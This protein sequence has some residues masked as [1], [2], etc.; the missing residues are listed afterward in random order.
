MTIKEL[1]DK[2]AE[3]R[4]EMQ[5]LLKVSEAEKRQLTDAENVLFN[6][7]M[8]EINKVDAEIAIKETELQKVELNK[9]AQPK[10]FSLLKAIQNVVNNRSF[11]DEEQSVIEQGI[12]EMRKSGQ[13]YAGQI[14]LPVEQR[15]I[16]A[17]VAGQGLENVAT[18]KLGILEPLRNELVFVK[19]GATFLTGL[20]GDVSIPV[21]A[22]SNVTWKGETAAADDASS[23]WTEVLLQPKRLTAY[24]DISKQFLIQDSNNAEALL[25]SDIIRA[26]SEKLESTLLGIAAGTATSPSGLGSLLSP[27]TSISTFSDIVAIEGALESANT[28]GDYTYILAPDVKAAMRTMSKDAGSGRFVYD[29]KGE[30]N[31]YKSYSTNSVEVGYGYVGNW[32]DYVL[33]QWG[34]VDIV[35]DPYSQA[36]NGAVRL[37]VNAYFDG[38]PRR[39]TSFVGFSI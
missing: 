18:D 30:I 20:V 21:Y 38:K 27:I 22:G 2:K 28:K 39:A 36:V 15:D 37:V 3:I 33:A 24:L 35:V 23:T 7:K 6:N 4:A 9:R 19:A 26:I 29:D 10:Q 32:N 8:S 12:K 11:S 13:S 17:T 31:G 14:V 25:R 5:N 1:N 34:G 16:L